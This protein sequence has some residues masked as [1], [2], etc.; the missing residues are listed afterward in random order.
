LSQPPSDLAPIVDPESGRVT[1]V[2]RAFFAALSG[3][4]A[5]AVAIQVS[6][7][8]ASY[9]APD[10]GSLM[11][12]GGT[13]TAISLVRGRDPVPLDAGLHALPMSAGDTVL[14]AYS[15]APVM[16]FLPR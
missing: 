13:V 8:P 14:V 16:V 4:A 2:W 10:N 15:V 12:T 11:L 3:K 5:A 9:T 1:Q 6:G 7:S